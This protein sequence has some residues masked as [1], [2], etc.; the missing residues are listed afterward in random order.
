MFYDV[1]ARRSAAKDGQAISS[2][3]HIDKKLG[4]HGE[5]AA[6]VEFDVIIEKTPFP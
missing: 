5:V 2:N 4:F 3:T 1:V 6:V